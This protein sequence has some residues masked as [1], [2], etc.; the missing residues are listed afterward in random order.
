MKR[1]ITIF[2]A[3]F[4]TAVA[5]AMA[6]SSAWAR[7]DS[8]HDRIWL[9]GSAC[10][11][12]VAVHMLP[13]LAR[14][15]LI[16]WPVWAFCLLAAMHGHAGFFTN[17]G[18]S[19]AE[20]RAASSIQA[21][22]IDQRRAAIE[23][24]LASIKARPVTTVSAQLARTTN[25]E[26]A[27]A[28]RLELAESKRAAHLRDELVRLAPVASDTVA[29]DPVTALLVAVTGWKPEAVTLAINVGLAALLEVLGAMLWLEAWR[30]P[31]AV[32]QTTT[33]ASQ[34]AQESVEEGPAAL[35]SDWDSLTAAIGRGELSARVADIRKFLRCGQTRA[36]QLRRDLIAA[37]LVP[38]I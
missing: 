38:A 26:R 7:A 30:A 11:F 17:A 35:A 14:R 36:M 10:A 6:A 16:V 15:S 24:T 29:T 33:K 37:G 20:A 12:V 5:L 23:Q 31:E 25:P 18:Q 13:S 28:L 32:A 27:E 22:S 1:Q 2:F 8:T 4:V 9:V 21:K 3:C 34:A 19:A